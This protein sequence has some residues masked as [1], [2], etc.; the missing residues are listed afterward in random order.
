LNDFPE[1]YE[2]F[3]ML[4]DQINQSAVL[5]KDLAIRCYSCDSLGH[6]IKKCPLLHYNPDREFILKKFIFTPD[7]ERSRIKN[8]RLS[9]FK[10]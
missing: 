7:N 5:N 3:C 2:K 4:K 8:K 10:F 6:I 1:D 9:F